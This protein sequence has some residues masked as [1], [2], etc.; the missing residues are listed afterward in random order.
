MILKNTLKDGK[1]YFWTRPKNKVTCIVVFITVYEDLSSAETNAEP[2][3]TKY[4]LKSD[5]APLLLIAFLYV[6]GC[7]S[8]G[9]FMSMQVST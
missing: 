1:G 2:S 6:A 9:L 7:G 8:E 3:S 5:I 4:S